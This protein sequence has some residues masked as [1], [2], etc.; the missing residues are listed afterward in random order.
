MDVLKA[1]GPCRFDWGRGFTNIHTEQSPEPN[2]W[3]RCSTEHTA[4]SVFLSDLVSGFSVST[5]GADIPPW[6]QKHQSEERDLFLEPWQFYSRPA[7]I[8]PNMKER[9]IDYLI[10]SPLSVDSVGDDR[11]I[12]WTQW[13]KEGRLSHSWILR[14]LHHSTEVKQAF[15]LRDYTESTQTHK[16]KHTHTH[17]VFYTNTRTYRYIKANIGNE[18]RTQH[19]HSTRFSPYVWMLPWCVLMCLY[20]LA[21]NKAVASLKVIGKHHK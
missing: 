1:A 19:K 4:S 10:N 21:I 7:S 8:C 15:N 9:P 2:K 6:K 20:L 16:C 5:S 3:T 14:S 11:Y 18:K 13:F 12:E 17:N